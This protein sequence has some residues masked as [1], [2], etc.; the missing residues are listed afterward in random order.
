MLWVYVAHFVEYPSLPHFSHPHTHSL[1]LLFF[2][3]FQVLWFFENIQK[4]SQPTNWANYSVNVYAAKQFFGR[5]TQ[6][7][8]DE[9]SKDAERFPRT[10][11]KGGNDDGIDGNDGK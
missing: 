4:K 5:T 7:L 8:Q 3:L 9:S 1:P 11:K 10:V 6:Q 2:F